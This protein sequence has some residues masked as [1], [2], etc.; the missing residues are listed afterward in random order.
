MKMN[1][2]T[3]G[4]IGALTGL[5]G[6]VGLITTANLDTANAPGSGKSGDAEKICLLSEAPFF[7]GL[8]AGCYSN[9]EI[10][11]L[12]DRDLVNERGASVTVQMTSPPEAPQAFDNCRTCSDYN[13]MRRLGW[14]ALTGR[15]QRRE[16]FFGRACAML[17]F[18]NKA[19]DSQETYF[20]QS[21]LVSQDIE[22]IPT[23]SLI[24]F[25]AW[26]NA[27][28]GDFSPEE[29]INRTNSEAPDE[30]GN[31]VVKLDEQW[32]IIQPL[33]HAD[34]DGDGIG[35]ML[36]FMRTQLDDASAFAS[37][38]GYLSKFS[39]DGALSFNMLERN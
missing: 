2:I 12:Y 21:R 20:A 1:M 22:K 8:K 19:A 31:W 39:D 17:D 7:Q 13:R 30:N 4:T 25:S 24:Q 15:D 28:S 16:E 27:E 5:V 35:D 3:T 37:S 29:Q 11:D 18:L 10:A 14:F 38:V 34:F 33:A 32:L 26:P 9:K 6:A 36:V 23:K